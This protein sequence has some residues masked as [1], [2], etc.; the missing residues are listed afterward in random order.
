MKDFCSIS[1][2]SGIY[3]IISKVL[4]NHMSTVIAKNNFKPQN[5]FVWSRQILVI[6]LVA[7]KRLDSQLREDIP[8]V[9]CKLDMEKGMIM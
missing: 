5:F 3:K 2:V 7:N 8:R 9:I 4:A 1:L 6:E